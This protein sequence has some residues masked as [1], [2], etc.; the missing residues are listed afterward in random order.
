MITLESVFVDT[1][2]WIA[3]AD[4]DDDYHAQATKILPSV[5]KDF[6]NVL[7]SNLV[8]AESYIL[9]LHELGYRASQ[10][11]LNNITASFR[12]KVIY[13]TQEVEEDAKAILK[14][15]TD[16]DFSYTDAVSFAIMKKHKIEKA[17]SF[18]KHF[19]T[20]GFTRIP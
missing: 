8:I 14:K 1:G 9:M 2:A 20:A 13:S 17:F 18:D 4:T 15:Y 6:R 11:F 16:Q 5:L 3:L 12:I 19:T 7:T 10:E